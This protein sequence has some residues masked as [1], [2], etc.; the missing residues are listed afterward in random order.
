[1]AAHANGSVTRWIGE[2]RRRFRRPVSDRSDAA[3][4]TGRARRIEDHLPAAANRD[5]HARDASAD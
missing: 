3:W 1:M 5:G 2:G 4:R